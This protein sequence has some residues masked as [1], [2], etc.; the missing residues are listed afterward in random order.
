MARKTYKID[1][2]FAFDSI[3]MCK[4]LTFTVDLEQAE[5]SADEMGRYLF[6]YALH[7]ILSRATAGCESMAEA[8]DAV[9]TR[10][11]NLL[12]GVK[13]TGG[14]RLDPA[15]KMARDKVAAVVK[16]KPRDL[17]SWDDL[18]KY[19]KADKLADLRAWAERRVAEDAAF[20]VALSE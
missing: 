7:V 9:N 8:Q 1:T 16:V 12:A 4:G 6:G 15:F 10:I 17:K 2:T 13:G 5:V 11:A 3:P 19:V 14:P 18:G 20:I